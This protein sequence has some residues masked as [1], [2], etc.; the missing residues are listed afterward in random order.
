MDR[1]IAWVQA[2]AGKPAD[3]TAPAK[4]PVWGGLPP[5]EQIRF[6]RIASDQFFK[7]SVPEAIRAF[8]NLQ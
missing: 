4:P 7:M 3:T 1:M 5:L 2:K 8:L 6:P